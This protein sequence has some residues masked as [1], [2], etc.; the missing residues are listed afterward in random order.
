MQAHAQTWQK[1]V[2]RVI[3][4]QA[5][6]TVAAAGGFAIFQGS[7]AALSALY[8]GAITLTGSGWLARSIRRAGDAAAQDARRGALVLYMGLLQKYAFVFGALV[9]GVAWLRL[10]PAPLLVGFAVTQAGFLFAAIPTRRA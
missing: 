4:A 9:A 6:L 2:R 3:V 7:A 5:L 8:G 10:A 1:G